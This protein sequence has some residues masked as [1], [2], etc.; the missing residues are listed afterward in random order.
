[1]G[2]VVGFA[3]RTDG[4]VYRVFIFFSFQFFVPFFTSTGTC[5]PW[6]CGDTLCS[7]DGADLP[8]VPHFLSAFCVSVDRRNRPIGAGSKRN[9]PMG[10]LGLKA[11]KRPSWSVTCSTWLLGEILLAAVT[12]ISR[13]NMG[14]LSNQIE[15]FIKQFLPFFFIAMNL[16]YHFWLTNDII[17]YL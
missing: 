17:S 2:R 3:R 13:S 6:M 10:E 11:R 7:I 5:P 15:P 14:I 8:H 4:R 16:Q 1:M 12:W 9:W